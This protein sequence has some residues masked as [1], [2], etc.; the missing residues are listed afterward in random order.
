MNNIFNMVTQPIILLS[1]IILITTSVFSSAS[2]VNAGRDNEGTNKIKHIS[3]NIF[4]KNIDKIYKEL[5]QKSAFNAGNCDTYITQIADFLLFKGG[6]AYLPF[7]KSDYKTLQKRSYII[8]NKLFALRLLLGKKLKEFH[9]HREISKACVGKIRKAFRYSRFLEEFITEI[10]INLQKKPLVSDPR[11]YSQQKYQF[12][13]NP[14]YKNFQ[15]QSGDILLTRSSSFLSAIIARIGDEDSQFSHGAMIHV[16][17]KGEIQVIEAL[18]ETGVIITPYEE[19]RENNH[20][21]RALI[22]RHHNEKLAK[23]AAQKLYDVIQERLA[24]HDPI[25][26]DFGM[27]D[28]NTNQFFCSELVQYAF[29]LAGDTKLPAFTTSF[30]SFQNHSFLHD[31]TIKV[32]NGFSPGDLEVEP[33]INLVGEWRDYNATL[34]ARIQDVIQTK[35]FYW[36]SEKHYYLQPT[37]RS[38]IGT[39]IVL[40]GRNL[41][42]Y[43]NDKIPVNMPYGFLENIIKLDDLN[44][45]LEKYLLGLESEYFKKHGHS[46]DY[47]RMME[48]MEKFRIEDCKAYIKRNKEMIQKLHDIDTLSEPYESPKPIFHNLFNTN[49][50]LDCKL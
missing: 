12:Y 42:G 47:F 31:L 35:I 7:N 11:D 43:M 48:V 3:V 17:E 21:A 45:V 49:N 36:M 1:F 13:L 44:K 28:S 30:K 5:N 16:D 38:F 14:R 40:L 19:W 2:A 41:F 15:F 32:E 9:Q 39:N 37:F 26:Y 24:A 8:V 23:K 20:H 10:G 6:K 33:Q 22:F 4:E 34:L 46:M 18:I 29:R 25:L 27:D 50:G